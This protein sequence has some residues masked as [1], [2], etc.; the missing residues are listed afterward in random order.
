MT[1]PVHPITAARE[2]EG[3]TVGQLAARAAMSVNAIKDLEAGRTRRPHQVTLRSLAE[4]LGTSADVLELELIRWSQ[5][6]N[7]QREAA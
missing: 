6:V 4:A 1:I 2:H 3:M 7:A 5:T